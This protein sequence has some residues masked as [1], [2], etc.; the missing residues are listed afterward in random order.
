[1]FYASGPEI[2]EY[3]RKTTTKWNLDKNVKFN[4]KI[5]SSIWNDITSKWDLKIETKDGIIA[6]SCDVLVNGS[7]ILKSVYSSHRES[8]LAFDSTAF[9]LTKAY[10]NWK[11]P[12]IPG[13]HNFKGHLVHT[14]EWYGH[15]GF[16]R[17]WS[18]LT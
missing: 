2:W 16:L 18:A 9:L 15:S 3:I 7:G 14:A 5:I 12:S 13:L 10:S 8:H 17:I 4:S 6:D 11:W 1:M